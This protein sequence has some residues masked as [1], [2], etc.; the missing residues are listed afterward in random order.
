MSTVLLLSPP[1]QFGYFEDTPFQVAFATYLGL[2]CPIMAPLAGRSFGKK[3]VRLDRYGANLAAAALPGQGHRRTLNKLQSILQ[4]MMKLGGIHTEKEAVNFIMDEVGEPHI[5]SYINHVTAHS[6]AKKA[7][8]AIIPDLH[9]LN[10]PEGKQTINNSGVTTTAEAFFET[11]TYTACKTRYAHNNNDVNKSPDRRAK[12]VNSIYRSKFKK[13][14]KQFA[15]DIV[16][17]G[18]GD[19]AGPFEASQARFYRGQVPLCAGWFVEINEDFEKVI[20]LLAREAAAGDDGMGISPLANSDKKGGAYTI[21]LNQFRRAIGCAI[22]RGQAQHKLGRLHYVR[23][24]A[25]EAASVCRANHSESSW[26]PSQR[27]RSSW[28]TANT[29]E[30]Y[31]TFEQ[32]RNGHYFNVH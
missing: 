14:D 27:G 15:A 6:S 30:G 9:A 19:M 24:T 32:F 4:A 23:A 16:G 1:D 13:L 31:S 26:K 28:Y 20:K 8:F 3:G 5:S 18:T 25:A 12:E 22:I 7:T 29:P 11:K 21:M 10:F 2:K 17:N